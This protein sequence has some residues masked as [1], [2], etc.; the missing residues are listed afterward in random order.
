MQRRELL[1]LMGAGWLSGLAFA[2]HPADAHKEGSPSPPVAGRQVVRMPAPTFTLVDQE[3]Y[4]FAFRSWRGR[5]LLVTFGF[6]TCRD[7]C[8]VL[9][10]NVVIIQRELPEVDRWRTG[11]L[12]ITTDPEHDSPAVLRAYGTKLG[13]DF[14]TWKFLTGSIEELEPVWRGFGVSVRKRGPGQVDHTMLATLVDPEGVRRVNYYGTRWHPQTVL[15]DL[16]A[17]VRGAPTRP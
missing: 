12:F 16:V 6:T 2:L 13:A 8:P 9:A 14:S 5:A 1:W 10:A 15:G 4:P 11:L 17:W 3:D 7:V